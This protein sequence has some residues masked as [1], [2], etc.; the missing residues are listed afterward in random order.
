[1]KKLLLSLCVL[2]LLVCGCSQSPKPSNTVDTFL[3][4]RKNLGNNNLADLGLG[5]LEGETGMDFDEETLTSLINAIGDYD[6]VVNSEKEDGDKATVNVTITTYDFSEWISNSLT[7]AISEA[8]SLALAGDTSDEAINEAM[9]KVFKEQTDAV[10]AAGKTKSTTVDIIC[11]KVDG[12]WEV[13]E[14]ATGDALA[15]ALSGGMLSSM[16]GLESQLES[17]FQ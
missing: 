17:M 6:Y 5:S 16:E 4:E 10:I 11:K 13:D 1:M 3:K 9:N 12:N 7:G 15:D 14:Q 2:C 8:F